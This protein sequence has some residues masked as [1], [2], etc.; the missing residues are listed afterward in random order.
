[1]N[2]EDAGI[3]TSHISRRFLPSLPS[4]TSSWKSMAHSL[5]RGSVGKWLSLKQSRL[6]LRLCSRFPNNNAATKEQI[7]ENE[8]MAKIGP[9]P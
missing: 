7:S 3:N 5:R 1:M 8:K 9:I 2:I 6:Y 4:F